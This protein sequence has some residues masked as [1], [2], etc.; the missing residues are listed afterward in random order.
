MGK[1]KL[2]L[3]L[4]FA[5]TL[6]SGLVAGMLVSRLPLAGAAREVAPRT[7]LAEELG[8]TKEQ[9]EKMRDI[10]E[11]VRSKVDG[12]F[13]QAQELQKRRDDALLALLTEEQK[14]KFAKTQ[15]ECGD[16]LASLKI[17]RDG[18]FQEAVKRTEQILSEPQKQRYREILKSRLGHGPPG[19]PP[20]WIGPRPP[21]TLPG[22]NP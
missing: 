15:Q 4:M 9:S 3:T 6:S 11:G 2:I 18:V 14:A 22:T 19:G 21:T 1:A 13:G 12:C 8:L 7:P 5:L 20:D 10:W 17:E 16:A